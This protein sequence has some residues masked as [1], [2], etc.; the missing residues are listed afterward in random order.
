MELIKFFSKKYQKELM[1]VNFIIVQH[2]LNDTMELITDLLANKIQIIGVVIKS[3]S[4]DEKNVDLLSKMKIPHV[5]VSQDSNENDTN[6]FNYL[7]IAK[8]DYEKNNRKTVI[9]DLGG[10]FCNVLSQPGDY[11]YIKA[12]VEDT[13]FGHRKY[14]ANL[15]NI[16]VPIFSVAES[17]CKELEARFVGRTIVNSTED[18]LRTI[19]ETLYARNV[20]VFG[21]GMIGKNVAAGL[22]AFGCKV[23]VCEKDSVR[24]VDAYFDGFDVYEKYPLKPNL[25]I[26]GT[27]GSQVL[28]F[29]NKD[30][31]QNNLV[32]VSGSS[33][34]IEFNIEQIKKYA[35]KVDIINQYIK[36]YYIDGKRVTV[37]ND[38]F[39]V[40]FIN[41]SIPDKI[42]DLLFAEMIQ[43]IIQVDSFYELH[44]INIV[45]KERINEIIN[46]FFENSLVN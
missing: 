46:K 18:I 31:I 40:N 34:N 15:S 27:T 11:S 39:P 22:K 9:L 28:N 35:D 45:N 23:A 44:K 3:Y 43:S 37:I 29:S 25:F 19:G 13:A 12:I 41:K 4:C 42:I 14:L 7:N 36:N 24:R 33:K 10:E 30:D 16:F 20:L 2:L 8:K 1:E 38:G 32:L 17:H 26:I 6:Y 21:Y 5:Y